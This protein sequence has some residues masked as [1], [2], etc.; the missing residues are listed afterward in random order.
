MKSDLKLTSH[1]IIL[2][3]VNTIFMFLIH[4]IYPQITSHFDLFLIDVHW[5]NLKDGVYVAG[6]A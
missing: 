3:S 5:C 6:Y 1:I 4:S 2:P